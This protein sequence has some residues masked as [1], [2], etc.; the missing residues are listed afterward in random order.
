MP[1]WRAMKPLRS[2]S[3]LHSVPTLLAIGSASALAGEPVV[4]E[5]DD[6]SPPYSYVENG[7]TKGIYVDFVRSAAK[8][9]APQYDVSIHAVPWKR[10]LQNLE[11][12][13]SLAFMPPYLNQD[14]SFIASYSPVL[15][16]ETI[17]LFC[18]PVVLQ[19]PRSRFPEDFAGLTIGVNLG[20][21]LGERMVAAV[22]SGAIRTEEAKGN[23]SN[24][25]KLFVG[26][27]DC[28]ANDRL[29]T[30]FSASALLATPRYHN[31]R[32][33]EA[34]EISGENAYIG[35]SAAYQA[36]FKADFIAKMNAALEAQRKTGQLNKLV[37]Q[38]APHQKSG[39]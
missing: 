39:Q 15:L 13:R 23:E 35:Y 28:F 21:A 17:V 22:K 14:R 19:T 11:R 36:P 32:L 31:A 1:H 7:E 34:V 9:L 38:Y 6:S 18:A 27:I 2:L 5:T 12:G 4:I 37:E 16:R 24:I 10:G 3:F 26:R 8:R 25:Q 29:S 33:L 30:R 20:F